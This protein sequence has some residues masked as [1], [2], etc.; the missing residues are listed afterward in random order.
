MHFI[1]SKPGDR[2]LLPADL[3]LLLIVV[4]EAIPDSFP[5]S[6]SLSHLRRQ[7]LDSLT[8]HHEVRGLACFTYHGGIRPF[9]N[10]SL[11]T[12]ARSLSFRRLDGLCAQRGLDRLV[13]FCHLLGQGGLAKVVLKAFWSINRQ[14]A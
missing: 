1:E 8:G 13:A 7:R 12:F 9:R 2:G 10:F 3:E 4:A 14:L 11:A 6:P 5:L